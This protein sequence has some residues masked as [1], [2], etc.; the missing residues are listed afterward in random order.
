MEKPSEA[1]TLPTDVEASKHRAEQGAQNVDRARVEAHKPTAGSASATDQAI[2][3]PA[4]ETPKKIYSRPASV[5]SL[6]WSNRERVLY[7]G[8]SR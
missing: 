5:T 1:P 2:D 3:A 7:A 8:E 6:L 4:E